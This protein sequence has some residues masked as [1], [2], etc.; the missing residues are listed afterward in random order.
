MFRYKLIISFLLIS[1]VSFCGN[2]MSRLLL[3]N[4]AVATIV[5]KNSV[6]ATANSPYA[7]VTTAAVD[8]SGSDV[9]YI[10]TSDYAFVGAVLT[11]L[12]DNLGNSYPL[13]R[14]QTQAGGPRISIYRCYSPSG[15]LSSMT[16]TY[17]SITNSYPGIIAAGFSGTSGAAVD[18]QNSAGWGGLSGT[19]SQQPGSITPT[20]NGEL[21]IVAANVFVATATPTI[22]SGFSAAIFQQSNAGQT[23]SMMMS[24][25]I[26]PTASAINPTITFTP[27]GSNACGLI[28]SSK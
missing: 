22:N 27:L 24:Y 18:H 8:M 3:K 17:P 26:Q 28:I 10:A 5:F 23:Y 4:N 13:I 1:A 25:Y 6:K 9:I 16:F 20:Q 15:A 11:S 2:P 19:T 12:T 14:S 21:I 7:T